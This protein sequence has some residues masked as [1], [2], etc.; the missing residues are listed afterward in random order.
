[1]GEAYID[2]DSIQDAENVQMKLVSVDEKSGKY[3]KSEVQLK[4]AKDATTDA[5]KKLDDANK[6]DGSKDKSKDDKVKEAQSNLD[7]AKDKEKSAQ[8][9]VDKEKQ[10]VGA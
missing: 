10:K 6:I 4:E 8:Q 5:Q 1:M 9:K 3:L 2:H 7:S